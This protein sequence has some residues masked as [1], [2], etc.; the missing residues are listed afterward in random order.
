[1][2]R[3]W[4][5]TNSVEDN[6]MKQFLELANAVGTDHAHTAGHV[7]NLPQWEAEGRPHKW[8]LVEETTVA[9]KELKVFQDH[10]YG[11]L[12]ALYNGKVALAAG[13]A[14]HIDDVAIILD[15]EYHGLPKYT[16][17]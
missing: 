14:C 4:A 6:S 8:V 2:H 12:G 10:G 11:W 7:G 1:M 15:K 3:V 13:K 16:W 17:V 9:G 5:Q